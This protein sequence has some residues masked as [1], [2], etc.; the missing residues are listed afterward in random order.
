MNN[1][2]YLPKLYVY[3][4]DETLYFLLKT[5]FQLFD[6]FVSNYHLNSDLTDV[7]YF[8]LDLRFED[9]KLNVKD[10]LDSLHSH[11]IKTIVIL[12]EYQTPENINYFKQVI[13][14]SL[15]YRFCLVIAGVV[16]NGNN[17]VLL[18][19]KTYNYY[20]SNINKVVS[21]DFLISFFEKCLFSLSYQQK[22][23]EVGN[24]VLID[25]YNL[26]D[27][28]VKTS[29]LLNDVVNYVPDTFCSYHDLKRLLLKNYSSIFSGAEKKELFKQ[30]QKF[31]K[32]NQADND[33][34]KNSQE[35]NPIF[36]NKNKIK[37]FYLRNSFKKFLFWFGFV[38][39]VFFMIPYFIF[40]IT[41]LT[42]YFHTKTDSEDI[43]ILN[44]NLTVLGYYITK[45]Y[46]EFPN[47]RFLY[48]DFSEYYYFFDK[49]VFINYQEKKIRK[50]LASTFENFAIDPFAFEEY[51][52][53]L[54]LFERNLKF[55]SADYNDLSEDKKFALDFFIGPKVKNIEMVSILKNISVDL[56]KSIRGD[57][58]SQIAIVF[59]NNKKIL[60]FGGEI[61]KVAII[62]LPYFNNSVEV[63]E[64]TELAEKT[65]SDA[66]IDPPYS[67]SEFSNS[68]SWNLKH[69]MWNLSYDQSFDVLYKLINEKGK[70]RINNLKHIFYVDVN[71]LKSI[72]FDLEKNNI[73]SQIGLLIGE[74]E[75]GE[76]LVK[77]FRQKQIMYWNKDL[78]LQS[79]NKNAL[80]IIDDHKCEFCHK[81]L[82]GVFESARRERDQMIKNVKVEIS[83]QEGVIKHKLIYFVE[84]NAPELLRI[85]V[86][87][88]V[89]VG[90]VLLIG[91]SSFRE[92]FPVIEVDDKGKSIIVTRDEI[93]DDTKQI[94]FMW[95][96]G[97]KANAN[98]YQLLLK[99]QTGNQVKYTIN[100][101]LPSKAL[102]STSDFV[103]T[104]NGEYT[105][106]T[107]L[108]RDILLKLE[109]H[110]NE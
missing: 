64:G 69:A 94:V 110:K 84:K 92:I 98:E 43:E 22:I 34:E 26:K 30:S 88:N 9:K 99:H 82:L 4:V 7:R 12:P 104:D 52:N 41:Y 2:P 28:L 57:T 63:W 8:L 18:R 62:N 50:S 45:K 105:Y 56:L 21:Y 93:R 53:E 15:E 72:G 89:G 76:I 19:S 3:T 97:Y 33:Y 25:D 79:E 20:F 77:A 49:Y 65:L 13:D 1:L 36:N 61:E 83:F 46:T 37:F 95:E 73:H 6:C 90:K 87:A 78:W 96:S 107:V 23:F 16:V 54:V 74:K 40:S 66:Q 70:E 11:K 55:L 71:F 108:L 101:S 48:K 60:G 39:V 100:L 80:F 85:L 17:G 47:L 102:I 44:K 14:I 58:N 27:Y 75:V 51:V 32:E 29:S 35:L 109:F 31:K 38:V 106:N 103:L 24:N 68:L 86:P 67:L 81:D 5:H 91:Q 10:L 42:A 59:A